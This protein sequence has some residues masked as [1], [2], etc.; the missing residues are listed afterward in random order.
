M[1]TLV[2][3]TAATTAS[4]DPHHNSAAVPAVAAPDEAQPQTIIVIDDTE[5]TEEEDIIDEEQLTEFQE[6][7]VALGSFPVRTFR[8]V[9]IQFAHRSGCCCRGQSSQRGHRGVEIRSHKFE[10]L[11][12]CLWI[13]A[14]C[15]S[16][17]YLMLY[18]FTLVGD[19]NLG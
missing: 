14:W 17:P 12:L 15:C 10:S 9:M 4:T 19:D 6:Q 7:L 5:G 3:S 11:R 18:S 1:A 2:G 16:I 8:M 13:V